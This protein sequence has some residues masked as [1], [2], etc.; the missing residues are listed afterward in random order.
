MVNKFGWVVCIL[1]VLGLAPVLSRPCN[2]EDPQRVTIEGSIEIAAEDDDGNVVSVYIMDRGDDYLVL[3]DGRGASLKN[4]V[5]RWIEATGTAI[6][7][8]EGDGFDFGL[9]VD[10]YKFT[11]GLDGEE[12]EDS[13]AQDEGGSEEPAESDE[14]QPEEPEDPGDPP[15]D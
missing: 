4:H 3:A 5:G 12:A 6:P 14:E 2:A 7:R 11:D 1:V 15:T 9:R 10:N 13:A 8:D